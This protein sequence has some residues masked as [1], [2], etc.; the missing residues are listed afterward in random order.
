MSSK[1]Q[2]QVYSQ[3]EIRK[4]ASA[5]DL[6]I[7]IDG[8]VY[9]LTRFADLHPGGAFP[10]LE[11]AGKDATDAFYG[12]HR[13][14]VLRKYDR[15][16]I[17]TIADF[18]PQVEW[19]EPG[20]SSKVPYAEPMAFQGFKSPYYNESHFKFRDAVRA[21]LDPMIEEAR[22][23]EESGEK[24]SD[25]FLQKLGAHGILA[26]NVG[27]G[28]WLKAF[29]LPGGIS[30]DE[31]DHFHELLLHGEFARFS[32]PGFTSGLLGGM[33]ISVPTVLNFGSPA[34]RAKVIPEVFSGKKRMA[35]AITEPYTGSDVANIKTTAVKTP[36]GK[37]F[38][39]NGVKKWITT[40]H[41]A[42]YFSTAVRTE[43]GISMLLIERGEGVETKLIKTSYSP[44]AGTAYVTFEN[45]KVPVEH[46]LGKENKGFHV[47][48]S[49]FNRERWSMLTGAS[50]AARLAVEE[51]FKW[52]NQRQVFGK[53]LIDQPVIRFKLAKMIA[54][55]ESVHSWIE[56]L[57]YQ[58]DNMDYA[59]QSSKL[60]GPIA[61][62]KYK[63]TRMLHDV[64]DDACQI[65]GGRA[66]TKTGMGRQI[67][68]LQ[69]T[70]K[71][72]AILG[73]AEEIMADL[74]VRQAMKK[75][76]IGARL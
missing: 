14:D 22:Q 44:S 36:D 41:H 48:L 74:G 2:L 39:V 8:S 30:A 10:L 67:E 76:P 53:R 7:T 59:E 16:K 49:N 52:A 68:T 18:K 23:Y 20:S 62:C 32:A 5:D 75:F 69:R 65:F 19:R 63:V 47:V 51:C 73:G 54:S 33:T 37:H 38:I 12:L 60:A 27:P 45:V 66:I 29:K 71:F 58:M 57:T 11:F 6:W 61:L 24:P 1:K 43:K 21:I 42:D 17:G 3:E 50:M 4:H 26:A 64:S 40:G 72:T 35:L 46:L 70:Y 55:V 34:L 28:P 31:Y 25:E 56:H 13:Q 15:Y 9:D